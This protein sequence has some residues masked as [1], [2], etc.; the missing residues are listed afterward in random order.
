MVVKKKLS[1]W[2][3]TNIFPFDLWALFNNILWDHTE[4]K[5]KK[6]P[7]KAEIDS[8]RRGLPT[9]GCLA[10]TGCLAGRALRGAGSR[11]WQLWLMGAGATALLGSSC[12]AMRNRQNNQCLWFWGT[13]N[14]VPLL[15]AFFHPRSCEDASLH[16]SLSHASEWNGS[17]LQNKDGLCPA[18]AWAVLHFPYQVSLI[19][20][21]SGHPHPPTVLPQLPQLW[22]RPHAQVYMRRNP[23][24]SP[25]PQ[26]KGWA[27]AWWLC[28]SCLVHW[29]H[30]IYLSN[31]LVQQR[32]NP[33]S[34][35]W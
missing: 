1:F 8:R 16:L 10:C 13:C 26:N 7:A 30:L 6:K 20:L 29:W 34:S 18:A 32:E 35:W 9:S 19:K 14:M 25:T 24:I 4:E 33:G 17:T 5:T 2:R 31:P 27:A 28:A 12:L 21:D 15:W 3:K 23:S 22:P 11:G